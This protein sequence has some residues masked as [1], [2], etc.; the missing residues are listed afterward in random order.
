MRCIWILI[1]FFICGFSFSAF[2]G[3]GTADDHYTVNGYVKDV[4]DGEMLVGA[5][6]AIKGTGQ[7]TVTNAYG[8]FSLSLQSGKK[9]LQIGFLGYEMAELVGD[10]GRW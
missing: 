2:A 10:Y 5:T 6:I 7:G 4:R 9:T 3:L 1:V 8:F